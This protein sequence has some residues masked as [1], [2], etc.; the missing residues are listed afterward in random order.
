MASAQLPVNSK[1][2][3]ASGKRANQI[4][5]RLATVRHGAIDAAEGDADAHYINGIG[6]PTN[7]GVPLRFG[8]SSKQSPH[9]DEGENLY[10]L[11]ENSGTTDGFDSDDPANVTNLQY[12]DYDKA[13]GRFL[14]YGA[15]TDGTAGENTTVSTG[16][17]AVDPTLPKD[18]EFPARCYGPVPT[19]VFRTF[20]GF[21]QL[22]MQDDTA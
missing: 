2:T 19:G 7:S 4:R 8:L 6:R 17:I 14:G 5:R 3:F 15:F 10:I 20:H 18:I 12:A 22:K 9:C 11:F 1:I 16:G 13:T 21:A